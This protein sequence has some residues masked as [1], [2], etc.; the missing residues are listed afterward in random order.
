ME[1]RDHYLA[2]FRDTARDIFARR[3]EL[4][5]VVLAVSQYWND[6][7]DDAVHDW[8]V[9]SE[10]ELPLWPHL[11]NGDN[12]DDT[13]TI[14]N[15]PGE[16]CTSCGS[17]LGEDGYLRWWHDN[18][19]AIS[20][21]EAMCHEAGS[22]DFPDSLNALPAAIARRRGD[23]IEVELLGPV[24]R[25]HSILAGEP[26]G[27][28][29]DPTWSD[30]RAL[31]LYEQVCASP[32]DD[33]PRRVFADYLLE[34]EVARGDLLAHALAG[35]PA[36]AEILARDRAT[37]LDPLATIVPS[38]TARFDRGLLAEAEVFAVDRGHRGHPAL[39]S[40]ERL[41]VHAGSA[42]ILHPDMRALRELGPINRTWL[43]DLVT[44]P[45]PWAIATL[46]IDVS[47][48]AMIAMLRDTT[49]LPA[50]RH[51]IVRGDYAEQAAAGLARAAWWPQLERFTIVDPRNMPHAWHDRRRELA[52]PW[53]AVRTLHDDPVHADG[54]ELAFGP[55]NACE[56]TLRGFTPEATRDS[57]KQ[58]LAA[59][60]VRAV[61]LV[62]SRHYAPAT[63]D[64]EYLSRDGQ[65]VT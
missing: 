50:L 5:S 31:E 24:L 32:A 56:V 15:V 12:Y 51:L 57:L 61:K 36:Y 26:P 41:Y 38:D 52:V 48:E 62:A 3:P 25:P 1:I 59:T 58:L 63:V 8:I 37:W 17:L 33:G 2:H 21:F 4:R 47:D 39:S 44:T 23:A 55:D 60:P 20:A 27:T 54:W 14:E 45:R 43:E 49:T 53:L 42:S 28:A 64:A 22:Q 34:R 9:A 29:A 10:R 40:I 19:A 65:V 30:A 11:C 7:A 16:S 46:D 13:I 18:G 35:S 6:E